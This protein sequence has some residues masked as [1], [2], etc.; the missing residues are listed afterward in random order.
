MTDAPKVY[1]AI[2]A[3]TAALSKEGIGKTRRNQQQGFNYRGIDEVMNE[4]SGLLALHRLCILPRV[5]GRTV[6]ER[7]SKSG[8]AL[9][10]VTVQGEY[11]IVS[12]DDGSRHTVAMCGEAMDSADK[13]TNKATA[14]AYKYMAVQVFCIPTEGDNDADATSHDVAQQSGDARAKAAGLTLPGA[15]DKWE[16]WAGKPLSEVP[17]KTLKAARKWLVEKNDPKNAALVNAI[18]ATLKGRVDELHAA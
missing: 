17:E 13:A 15:A 7:Q 12:A 4:L 11:D 3:I 10:S 16:G 6:T 18:D 9:F 5:A 1:A 2:V 14:A 8:G